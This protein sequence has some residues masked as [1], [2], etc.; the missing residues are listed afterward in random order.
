MDDRQIKVIIGSLLHDIGKVAYR[1][2][3]GRNHSQTGYEFLKELDNG[4]DPEILDCV[5]YH[6]GV[7]LKNAN[8][9]NQ[10]LAYLTYYADNVASAMD[11]REGLDAEDGFDSK[12]PLDSV[13]N[14][15]NQNHGHQH[16]AH[17]VLDPDAE[18]NYPTDREV[19]MDES[20]YHE[21]LSNIRDNLR[22]IE[23]SD[24]YI[25][26]LLSVMEAQL[27]YIPSS[28]SKR[29]QADISL[30]DHVKIT[31]AIAECMYQYFKEKGVTDY[32]S[33][34]FSSKTE[35]TWK[36]P[37][38]L[39]YSMDLSGIQNFIYTISSKGALRGLRA[40]SFYLEILME[41]IIDEL[42]F[43]LQLSRSCLI[44]S[45]GGHCYLIVPNTESARQ[46][47]EEQ[48]HLVNEWFLEQFGTD[49]YIADGYAVCSANSLR[50]EPEGSYS[51][52]YLQISKQISLQKNHRYTAEQILSLNHHHAGG[53]RECIICRRQD[54]LDEEDRC[55]ICAA[56]EKLSGDILYHDFFMIML[57]PCGDS[58]PLP[59]GKYL[60]AG[61]DG[62]LRQLMEKD[63]Y[64]RS[65]TKNKPYTGKHV[66]T[67]LWV[68]NYTTGKTFEELAQSSEGIERI[69][70]LRGD[71][72]NL[73]A[74]FVSG[75]RRENDDGTYDG[76]YET[77]SRTAALSRQLSLFFKF[78]LNRLLEQGTSHSF[79]PSGK[80]HVCIVYSGGDDIFIVGAW[81]EVVDVFQDI[82]NA[83]EKFTEGTLTISGGIGLYSPSYPINRMALETAELEDYSKKNLNK[84]SV[85]LFDR[86]GRYPW[87]ELIQKVI[88]EKY[89]VI[90]DYMSE[91]QQRG[92]AFL[93]HLLELLR[94]SEE[95]ESVRFNRARFVYYLSRM[96]PDREAEEAEADAFEKFSQKMYEWSMDSEGR[97]QLVTA[98]YLY[99]YRTREKEGDR[100]DEN[101]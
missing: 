13:F 40:R 62:K 10:S 21:I 24:E 8:I 14:L 39:L 92:K 59:G 99:V 34:L 78:Y 36:E 49:L 18:I 79:S 37:M 89:R 93:Y 12:V 6:H 96:E 15:L 51:E 72:D 32:K 87:T 82:R 17:Q 58:L 22:G 35:E 27:S 77:L 26:S 67:R 47:L 63:T 88:G 73:G 66:A 100:E 95:N 33:V 31:A 90:S 68:G 94:E 64:V 20:F 81:N 2:G 1:A 42:L 84:N 56:L 38:F 53:K 25:N 83:M 69:A 30:Y 61:N 70:V 52:L 28:T 65:Y 23:I 75:F 48:N 55:S 57:E 44:Y 11:R 9:E 60:T 29:E 7:N 91:T 74:A 98:I 19:S 16:Y 54:Q 4:F 45:G 80:R 76:K 46:K 71:V 97:R 101:Q 5:R 41:H 3:D 86:S 43:C 85:T 50:N